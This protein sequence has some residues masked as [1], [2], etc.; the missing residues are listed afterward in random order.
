MVTILCKSFGK[1]GIANYM[2]AIFLGF[3]YYPFL[4]FSDEV[5]YVGPAESIVRPQAV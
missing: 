2:A 3:I 4:G 1:P 5:H